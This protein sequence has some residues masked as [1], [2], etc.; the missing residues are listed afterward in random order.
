MAAVNVRS[1][2]TPA[3]PATPQDGPKGDLRPRVIDYSTYHR[4]RYIKR[5]FDPK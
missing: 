1:R 2:M 4:S 3:T 5:V